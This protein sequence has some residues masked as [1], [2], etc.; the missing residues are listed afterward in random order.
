[1]NSITNLS[2]K[3]FRKAATIKDKITSLQN[4]LNKL[5]G[6]IEGATKSVTKKRRK[7]SKAAR[8]KIAAAARAR[9]ARV[10]AMGKKKSK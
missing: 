3:H 1:M 7:M 4:E 8:A 5:L 2:A 10:K 9:W 6:L